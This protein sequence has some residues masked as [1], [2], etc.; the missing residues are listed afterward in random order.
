M[1]EGGRG[2]RAWR[3]GAQSSAERGGGGEAWARAW[4]L[5]FGAA[6]LQPDSGQPPARSGDAKQQS[7]LACGQQ[8]GWHATPLRFPISSVAVSQPG[9]GAGSTATFGWSSAR[10]ALTG[11]I[12]PGRASSK[13][14]RVQCETR[15]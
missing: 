12:R 1:R 11:P 8:H 6:G 14:R 5:T 10:R 2:G 9:A 15:E 4:A 7:G 13:R 3:G